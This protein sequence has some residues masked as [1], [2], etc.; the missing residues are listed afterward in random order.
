MSVDYLAFREIAYVERPVCPEY[1]RM[2]I[3]IPA[4]YREVA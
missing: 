3:F 1:Q 2:N 4:A